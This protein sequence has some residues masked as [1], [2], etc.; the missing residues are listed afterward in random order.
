[1]LELQLVNIDEVLSISQSPAIGQRLGISFMRAQQDFIDIDALNCKIRIKQSQLGLIAISG[2]AWDCGIALV[3]FLVELKSRNFL[4]AIQKSIYLESSSEKLYFEDV[5]LT[6]GE[7][8]DLGCGTG[9]CGTCA[10]ILGATNVV[11]TD[12]IESIYLEENF[13]S[14]NTNSN[15]PYI[16]IKYDWNDTVIPLSL[17]YKPSLFKDHGVSHTINQTSSVT[18]DS[19]YEWDTILCSD[20]LYEENIHNRLI[21]ILQT[22]RFKKLIISYKRRHDVPE[23]IFLHHLSSFCALYQ[24]NLNQI[25]MRNLPRACL[26]DLY[27]FIAFP[28]K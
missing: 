13:E 23:R 18:E 20:I 1:M 4:C 6:I 27:I 11:F 8:L 16:F 5:E 15:K 19:Y 2:V 3:D 26:S 9:I 25:S 7:C 24:V 28:Q 22:I 21:I 14:A 10:S 17:L 12:M